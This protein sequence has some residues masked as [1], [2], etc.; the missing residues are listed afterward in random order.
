MSETI[1]CPSCTQPM[2]SREFSRRTVGS[3]HVDLCFGC[4]LIWFDEHESALLAPAAVIELFREIQ[5]QRDSARNR[6][7]ARLPCPRCSDPL[8]LTHDVCKS[9]PL[10]YFRCAHD[11]GRLTPFFQ[12]LREKQFVRAVTPA[13]VARMR[14]TMKQVQCSNCGAPIDLTQGTTCGYCHSP[15]SI[16]D[17][18]AVDA[19]LRN[20]SQMEAKQRDASA[21]A[22]ELSAAL[23]RRKLQSSASGYDPLS[24]AIDGA[25]LVAVCIDAIAG[26]L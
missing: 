2:A 24:T 11:G 3:L 9:G 22:S 20:W 4:A 17:Q 19:A 12:F 26:L 1:H 8:A 6:V 7:A 18:N 14:A 5:S 16:L 25:D 15:V 23:D 13:E 10:Q 21:R